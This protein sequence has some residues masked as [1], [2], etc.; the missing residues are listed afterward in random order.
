M[1][2]KWPCRIGYSPQ[3]FK[4]PCHR[5]HGNTCSYIYFLGTGALYSKLPCIREAG[6]SGEAKL[7]LQT[8]WPHHWA[9]PPPPPPLPSLV[10][11]C[12]FQFWRK[13]PRGKKKLGQK[14][15]RGESG[16]EGRSQQDENL[17]EEKGVYFCPQCLGG[18]EK[19]RLYYSLLMFYYQK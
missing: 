2:T 16:S 19:C 6:V 7:F 4:L 11:R 13:P 8:A 14:K 9:L 10:T 12:P 1:S 15:R 5:M 18:G 3:Q 17:D